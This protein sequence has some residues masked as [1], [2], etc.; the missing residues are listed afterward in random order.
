MYSRFLVSHRG[1]QNPYEVAGDFMLRLFTG[2]TL[3]F[4]H[5]VGK[6]PPS[7]GFVNAVGDLGFPQ[8]YFFA[9]SAGLAEF[10]GGWLLALGFLTRP[11]AAFIAFTMIVAAFGRHADDPFGRKEL[12]LLYLF[13]ALHYLFSGAGKLSLDAVADS[14][15]RSSNPGTK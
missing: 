6:L 12:A 11:A 14:R 5:G 7:E 9:W 1:H 8:P 13:V 10:I 3:A 4:A 15:F 2:M